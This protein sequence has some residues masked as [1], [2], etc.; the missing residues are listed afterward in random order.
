MVNEVVNDLAP[1]F[2]SHNYFFIFVVALLYAG[3]ATWRSYSNQK[4]VRIA[5]TAYDYIKEKTW[6]SK[7]DKVLR[8]NVTSTYIPH[9]DVGYNTTKR[10]LF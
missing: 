5:T 1:Q 6:N 4:N 10:W 7:T 9:R 8:E 2:M 3:F